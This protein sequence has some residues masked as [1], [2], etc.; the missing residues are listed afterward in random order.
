MATH[1]LPQGITPA[2]TS[3]PTIHRLAVARGASGAY[4]TLPDLTGDVSRVT[5]KLCLAKIA[6]T[7]TRYPS[8]TQ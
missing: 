8:R 6:K 2:R 5:C 4:R 7:P 3:Q 1:Y